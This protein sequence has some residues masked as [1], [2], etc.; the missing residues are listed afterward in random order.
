MKTFWEA[1]SL[2][3][4]NYKYR[5]EVDVIVSISSKSA[6]SSLEVDCLMAVA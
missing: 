1:S 2:R 5:N 4:G 6:P 3:R